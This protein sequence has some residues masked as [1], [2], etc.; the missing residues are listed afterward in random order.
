[1]RPLLL[2]GLL[3]AAQ[4]NAAHGRAGR[5][6]VRVGARLPAG[7]PARAGAGGLTARRDARRRAP[8]PG[9]PPHRGGPGRL[10][11]TRT[12]GRLLRGEGAPRGTDG[13]GRDRGLARGARR[14]ERHAAVPASRAGGDDRHA[15]RASSSAG[16][17]SSIRSCSAS[18]SFTGPAA[19]FELE[20]DLLHELTQ[21]RVATYSDVTSF[22]A[23]LQDIAV[24][25]PEDVPAARLAEVVRAGGGRA[26]RLARGVRPLPRRA[27]GRGQQVA[28]PAARVPRARPHAHR[29]GGRRAP[30]GDR[31]GARVDRRPAPCLTASPS[32]APPATAARSPPRS[33]RRHPVARAR[34]GHRALGC[35]APARRALSALPGPAPARGVRPGLASPSGRPSAIVAYPHGAAAPAVKALRERG[36]KVVDLSADFR[37]D[38]ERYER[39]YQAH[40][41]PEL[42]DDAVYGLTEA[43]RDEITGRRARRGA[44]LL[45]DRRA[46]RALAAP[47]AHPRRGRGREVGRLRRRP[48]GHPDD[49]LR[50]GHRERPGLQ[51]RGPPPRRRARAGAERRDASRSCRTSFPSSRACSPAVT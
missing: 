34:G 47:R 20:V 37:L 36:L 9:G 19:A 14:R 16:S 28:R 42:L 43:H 27:G 13:G 45:P 51:G 11:H 7:R 35:R 30:R 40:A 5:G 44:R 25:V 29:R 12:R 3:D 18:G 8:P 46:P 22:P 6:A 4:H 50:L 24:I 49:P 41:A 48:R 10:A 39:W 1:M 31:D 17:G 33:C 23:V 26:A 21:G 32:S 15:P 2:P 38:R